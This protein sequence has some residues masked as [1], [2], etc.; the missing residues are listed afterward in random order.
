MGLFGIL[1]KK[2]VKKVEWN[3]VFRTRKME[4]K[5][6]SLMAKDENEVISKFVGMFH[7]AEYIGACKIK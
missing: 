7:R 1:R 6:V 3:V 4:V 2:D 5:S